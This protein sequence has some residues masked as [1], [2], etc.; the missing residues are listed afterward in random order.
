MALIWGIAES[1][2]FRD[3]ETDTILDLF[4]VPRQ[5]SGLPI[6]LDPSL[7][8]RVILVQGDGGASPNALFSV[9][10]LGMLE[11]IP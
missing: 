11:P 5:A 9:R 10:L 7:E 1:G 6:V 2:R 8:G 4:E 3:L